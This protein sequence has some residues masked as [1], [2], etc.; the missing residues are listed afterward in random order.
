MLPCKLTVLDKNYTSK[1]YNISDNI[2]NTY[3][4]KNLSFNNSN[5]N[6]VKFS[7]PNTYRNTHNDRYRE[8]SK[9]KS[10]FNDRR[11]SK[12]S[13]I[14]IN[15]NVK[16]NYNNYKEQSNFKNKSLN[17]KFRLNSIKNI[18]YSYVLKY[19]NNNE[20]IQNN[21]IVKNYQQ[22]LGNNS[23]L[24]NG[25]VMYNKKSYCKIILNIIFLSTIYIISI[26]YT[27]L[28]SN[29]NYKLHNIK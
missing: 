24:F 16:K 22:W 1:S 25:K 10:S 15:N 3:T 2:N 19:K 4:T 18:N 6:Q 5:Y 12:K 8:V 23:F 27:K 20:N 9:F 26:V 29:I 13:L 17:M 14:S 7:I 21:T 28:V 11:D